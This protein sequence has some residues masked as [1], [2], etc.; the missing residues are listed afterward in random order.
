MRS[1]MRLLQVHRSDRAAAPADVWRA[2][3]R[4]CRQTRY[5]KLFPA[6]EPKRLMESKAATTLLQRTRAEGRE[7]PQLSDRRAPVARQD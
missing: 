2:A 1:S 3:M 4:S 7:R 5:V 6:G